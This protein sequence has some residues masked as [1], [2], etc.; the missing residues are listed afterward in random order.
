M[1]KTKHAHLI[2]IKTKYYEQ[3]R[4]SAFYPTCNLPLS[5]CFGRRYYH[6]LRCPIF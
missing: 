4:P 5:E 6:Q 3:N 1:E 2:I